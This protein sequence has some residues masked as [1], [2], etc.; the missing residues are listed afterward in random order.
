L[1]RCR[2]AAFFIVLQSLFFVKQRKIFDFYCLTT[3]YIQS[4]TKLRYVVRRRLVQKRPKR[5]IQPNNQ[6]KENLWQI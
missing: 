4:R 2:A 6:F 1:S 3:K 5:I